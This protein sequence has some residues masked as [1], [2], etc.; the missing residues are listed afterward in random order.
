MLR[1]SGYAQTW[2]VALRFR[3][4]EAKFVRWTKDIGLLRVQQYQEYLA[5]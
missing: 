3:N 1:L 5:K 4:E 2:S